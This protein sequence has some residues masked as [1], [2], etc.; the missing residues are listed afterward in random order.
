MTAVL[1]FTWRFQRGD[2]IVAQV[3]LVQLLESKIRGPGQRTEVV[4][5]E[6]QNLCVWLDPVRNS[7]QVL[8]HT[9]HAGPVVL[10]HVSRTAGA[11]DDT[12]LHHEEDEASHDEDWKKPRHF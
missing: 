1:L 5:C 3:Q 2:V 10:V 4:L 9:A 11:H 6:N 7:R 12:A 8:T